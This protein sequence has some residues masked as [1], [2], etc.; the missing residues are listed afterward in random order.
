[1]NPAYRE[2]SQQ[3]EALRK[4]VAETDVVELEVLEYED[5][6]REIQERVSGKRGGDEQATEKSKAVSQPLVSITGISSS[7]SSSSSS[8]SS[9]SSISRPAGPIASLDLH[10]E[11][12]DADMEDFFGEP[13]HSSATP[14]ATP[15]HAVQWEA[16]QSPQ[17]V[18]TH[19]PQTAKPSIRL[20]LRLPSAPV[21]HSS[22]A[23]ASTVPVAPVSS[24]H[25]DLAAF[26][27][28]A[29][30]IGSPLTR[31]SVAA[32]RRVSNARST[33]PI[34]SPGVAVAHSPVVPVHSP[35]Q[36][37]P[38]PFMPS[39]TTSTAA[40][41][42]NLSRCSQTVQGG[43]CVYVLCWWVGVCLQASV[44]VCFSVFLCMC[45]YFVRVSVCVSPCTCVA[46]K[47]FGTLSLWMCVLAFVFV[48]VVCLRVFVFS[49]PP[50]SIYLYSSPP[51]AM[52]SDPE[53]V[54]LMNEKRELDK[55]RAELR[56]QLS[57]LESKIPSVPVMR[58]GILD[59]CGKSVFGR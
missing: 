48:F 49:L 44:N 45:P 21:E 19:T 47:L 8:V 27:D 20:V 46:S 52:G 11:D 38:Q 3:M 15:S 42:P 54:R 36:A 1:M 30:R 55:A 34:S 32:V 41:V 10:E 35:V 25:T 56:E 7:V 12:N 33:A 28:S 29:L 26:T 57:E 37:S 58:V 6:V 23:V 13:P 39:S 51:V 16:V 24:P 40:A 18:S 43:C 14:L 53:Y 50:P 2:I 9:V 31:P 22:P 59:L 4:G 17:L 5:M